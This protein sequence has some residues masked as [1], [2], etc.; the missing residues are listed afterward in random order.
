MLGGVKIVSGDGVGGEGIGL[1]TVFGQLLQGVAV[2]GVEHLMLQIV[3]DAG[4]SI[5]PL[6]IQLKAQ[7]HATVAGGKKGVF[8]GIAPLADDAHGQAVGKGLPNRRL[9]DAVISHFL[10]CAASFPRRKY[11]V[12]SRILWAAAQMR[13]GV[14]AERLCISSSGVSCWST[15]AR[16]I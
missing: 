9:P 15:A 5:Q 13:S 7:I 2:F 12:S 6:A 11:T 8:A 4:G 3:G 16:L 10:H 14:T 1:G